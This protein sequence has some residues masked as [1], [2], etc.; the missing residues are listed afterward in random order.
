MFVGISLTILK[1]WNKCID[2]I[3]GEDSRKGRT[4]LLGGG[5]GGGLTLFLPRKTQCVL[6]LKKKISKNK[7]A[8]KKA[9]QKG[10]DASPPA[11]TYIEDG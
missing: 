7:K 8:K 5:G 9:K 4:P 3:W 10:S 2:F 1:T 11:I 6:Q